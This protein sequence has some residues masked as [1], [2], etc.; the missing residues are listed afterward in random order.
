MERKV[1]LDFDNTIVSYDALFHALAVRKGLIDASLPVDKATV[2]DAVRALS[3]GE[4]TWQALQAVAY[5][6]GIHEARLFPGLVAFL[7]AC[8]AADAPVFVV[9]HKTRYAAAD[10][11][12]VDLHGCALGFMERHGL[13]AHGRINPAQVYFE[14]TRA[15]KL[16]RIHDLGCTHFVD[17]LPEVLL[18]DGFPRL[19]QRIFF[20]PASTGLLPG[21][22]LTQSWDEIRSLLFGT[23]ATRHALS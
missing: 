23:G 18:D 13:F 11:R 17:D 3:G 1:G 9:S 8:T 12:G 14:P 5:G 19:T 7:D 22:Q 10:P 15:A 4:K 16:R 20:S 2:R 6:S 21:T